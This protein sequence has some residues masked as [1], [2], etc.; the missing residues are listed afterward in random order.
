MNKLIVEQAL[1][2]QVVDIGLL[3]AREI[4]D[5][6]TIDVVADRGY[7]KAEDIEARKK[8][9]CIPHV[10]RPQRG[11]S[12]RE[13]LFRKNKFATTRGATPMS[14]PRAGC[15]RLSVTAGCAILSGSI[16][17]IDDAAGSEDSAEFPLRHA[18]RSHRDGKFLRHRVRHRES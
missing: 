1:T 2:N 13:G 7:F 16:T 9:G 14:A 3:T 6:E 5:V 8:A 17:T 4:L 12:V 15:C 18:K 10:P 11:T